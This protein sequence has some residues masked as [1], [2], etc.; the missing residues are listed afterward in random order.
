MKWIKKKSNNSNK[1]TNK[2]KRIYIDNYKQN[3]ALLD[4]RN[5][6][7]GRVASIS[8]SIL[9]GK[10]KCFY[11]CD[12]MLGDKLVIINAGKIAITGKKRNNKIYYYHTGHP[13]GLKEIF[14]KDIL[15]VKP[16]YPLKHAIRGMLPKNK[17]GRQLLKNIRIYTGSEQLQIN[18][19]DKIYSIDKNGKLTYTNIMDNKDVWIDRE[20]IEKEFNID[21]IPRFSR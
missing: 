10:N 21:P 14:Y 8:A 4:A 17:L 12:Q 6:V 15:K 3:W 2:S 20:R 5:M 18:K 16:E 9:M 19:I 13:G 7:L 11:S 1:I